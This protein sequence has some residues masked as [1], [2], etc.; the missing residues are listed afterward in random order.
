MSHPSYSRRLSLSFFF[1]SISFVFSLFLVRRGI[2][3]RVFR[4]LF[5]V[6]ERESKIYVKTVERT[7]C[8]SDV[9]WSQKRT[10]KLEQSSQ[11]LDSRKRDEMEE[12]DGTMSAK[13]SMRGRDVLWQTGCPWQ[14]EAAGSDVCWRRKTGWGKRHVVTVRKWQKGGGQR[15][16][17]VTSGRDP[18]SR[19]ERNG[20]DIL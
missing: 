9:L 2:L 17:K 7:F 19:S 10:Q 6:D 16:S 4:R 13:E 18:W 11:E 3:Q 1:I 8:S 15:D 14:D 20:D 5:T 12:R